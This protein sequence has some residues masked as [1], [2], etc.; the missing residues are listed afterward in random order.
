MQIESVV[1]QTIRLR[2]R[3]PFTISSGTTFQRRILLARIQSG[4]LTGWGEC[5]AAETPHYSYETVETAGWVL[6]EHLIPAVLGR[7]YESARALAADLDKAARGHPMAKAALEMAA[8]DL[9]ARLQGVSLASLLG[10]VRGAVPAGV[11]VGIQQDRRALLDRVDDFLREG[12]RRVKLKIAPGH[13]LD[14]VGAVRRE[15]PDAELTVDANGAYTYEDAHRL[16][17]LDELDLA[18]VEQPFEAD[19]LHDHH[20]LQLRM[21]TPLCLDESVTSPSSCVLALELGAGRV[22]NIKPGRVGG[23]SAGTRIHDFCQERG[24]PV[25]CG[26][27]LE[28]GIGRAHNVSLASLP[29][30]SLPGDTSASARYWE[31]DVVVPEFRLE[32]DGTVMVPDGVGI[33]VE[34]DEDFLDS[35]TEERRRFVP[36]KA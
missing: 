19:A 31:R 34:V 6:S 20:K 23:L 2:L 17:A 30:F 27:M 11:S 28:S 36:T 26:G 29:N 8:W 25:W 16:V 7:S 24:V 33:G 4:G 10:G 18:M 21:D 5:V 13:D 12:Y 15:F 14:V 9:E 1:L 32:P 22:V 35:I 3:E